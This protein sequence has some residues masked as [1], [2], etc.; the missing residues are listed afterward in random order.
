MYT[1]AG[2]ANPA[3]GWG[4]NGDTRNVLDAIERYQGE[5]WFL[6]GD[7]DFATHLLRT[8]RLTGGHS[9]SEITMNFCI[10][11]GI[12]AAV[13]PMTDDRV[14][15]TVDTPAGT[16][17]FQ[18]YFVRRRQ[19]D[20]VTGIEFEGSAAAVASASALSAIERAG[21]LV[22][23]PSNPIVSVGPILAVPGFH[24]A[25]RRCSAPRIAISPI[26]G[27]KALKGP[28]DKMLTSL[29]HESSA[30]GV[31]RL[32]EGLIDAIVID[33]R[34]RELTGS[35]EELGMGVLVTNSIMSS[36][37]DRKRLAEDVLEF[38]MSLDRRPVD[39]A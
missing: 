7:Q 20:E 17:S 32:Y 18:D 6:L 3:T 24:Q 30:L 2:M 26:V 21:V 37:E 13:L 39:M 22:I 1:L 9:L 5:S 11:L 38:A 15:T 29:G 19:T 23:C 35:I 28:A 14:A 31:A 27:G 36:F 4:I 12:D 33:H 16:L 34:D 10:A 8:E 25:V